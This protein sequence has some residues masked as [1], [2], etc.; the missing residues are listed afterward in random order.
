MILL[1]KMNLAS[2]N[3]TSL[4]APFVQTCVPLGMDRIY[5]DNDGCTTFMKLALPNMIKS[6]MILT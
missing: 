5:D 4:L 2:N 1:N 6:S 3:M